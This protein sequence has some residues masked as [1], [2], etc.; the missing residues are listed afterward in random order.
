MTGTKFLCTFLYIGSSKLP[1]DSKPPPEENNDISKLKTIYVIWIAYRVVFY[2]AT[3]SKVYV[4]YD[5]EKADV[6][7]SKI[8]SADFALI[9]VI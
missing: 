3:I 6:F 8:P 7:T 9:P 2:P 1:Y 5:L 4:F